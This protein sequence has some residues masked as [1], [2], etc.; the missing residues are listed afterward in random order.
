MGSLGDDR[1]ETTVD[2]DVR[3]SLY[4][5]RTSANLFE[6][7]ND[8]LLLVSELMVPG[9]AVREA[10]SDDLDL[11]ALR[12]DLALDRAMADRDEHLAA[13][14]APLPD[15]RAFPDEI[16]APGVRSEEWREGEGGGGTGRIGGS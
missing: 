3:R 5:L 6:I 15:E 7:A 14:P 1:A 10:A 4:A 11:L 2:T 16:Q 9:S 12:Y 8:E 13:A